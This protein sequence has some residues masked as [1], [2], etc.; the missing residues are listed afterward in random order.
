VEIGQE[1]ALLDPINQGEIDRLLLKEMKSNK[2][3]KGQ[4]H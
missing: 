4:A 3:Q 1:D 2:K